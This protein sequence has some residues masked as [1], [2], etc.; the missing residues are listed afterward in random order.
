MTAKTKKKDDALTPDQ[1]SELR[2][3]AEEHASFVK[4]GN[5]TSLQRD[6][7]GRRGLEIEQDEKTGLW[8]ARCSGI[9]AKSAANGREAFANWG[10]K[11]R[12]IL[13]LYA[14]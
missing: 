4:A 7:E 6:W 3:M 10:N 14:G 9:V 2:A 11:V 12:R 8:I 1:V 5:L 13:N